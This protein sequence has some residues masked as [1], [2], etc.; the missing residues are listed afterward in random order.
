MN[1]PGA[2]HHLNVDC[3]SNLTCRARDDR[4]QLN[5]RHH[6]RATHRPCPACRWAGFIEDW[7]TH[8][9]MTDFAANP[10]R[11]P[12]ASCANLATGRPGT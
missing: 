1:L 3:P 7:K 5:K 9:N 10:C 8:V 11:A 4:A 2:K 6:Q 12:S